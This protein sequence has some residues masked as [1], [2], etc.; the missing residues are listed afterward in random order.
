MSLDLAG[1]FAEG[2]D[3]EMR[4]ARYFLVGVITIPT[5]EGL[6]LVQS[7]REMGLKE[8]PDG[9]YQGEVLLPGDEKGEESGDQDPL[10]V[11]DEVLEEVTEGMAQEAKV[12]KQKWRQFIGDHKNVEVKNLTVA[13]PVRSRAAR[14]VRDAVAQLYARVRALNVPVLR[15]HTDRA[16]EFLSKEFRAWCKD[17]SIYHVHVRRR[18]H[19]QRPGRARARHSQGPRAGADALFWGGSD[20]VAT[21]SSRGGVSVPGPDERLWHLRVSADNIRHVWRREAEGVAQSL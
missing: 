16:K 5:E 19:G 12:L 9:P 17:R 6:P 8:L 15:V 14:V 21:R 13:I 2:V 18:A 7:L 11:Q 20:V 1:P 3:Q 10:Q 4:G